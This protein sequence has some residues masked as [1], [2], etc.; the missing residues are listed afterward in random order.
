MEPFEIIDFTDA[1]TPVYAEIRSDLE[2][3]GKKIGA[4][5]LLIAAMAKCLG[6][7]LVCTTSVNF[8]G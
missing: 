3:A 8:P 5:D 2:L 4:N 7:R 1:M 6:A